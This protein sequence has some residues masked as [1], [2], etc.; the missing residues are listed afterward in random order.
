M[1]IVFKMC[2]RLRI[3][4]HLTEDIE[5]AGHTSQ[6]RKKKY[7]KSL[8]WKSHGTLGLGK[9]NQVLMEDIHSKLSFLC[10]LKI[11]EIFMYRNRVC[12]K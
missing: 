3:L 5:R 8:L 6:F 2:T 10:K 12:V 1:K 7:V 9:K 4:G 11:Y